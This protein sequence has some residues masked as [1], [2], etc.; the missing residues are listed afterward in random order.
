MGISK[1]YADSGRFVN[2]DV[3]DGIQSN[4]F[5]LGAYFKGKDGKFY[6]GGMNGYNVFDPEDIKYNTDKPVT[7]VA[8][9]RK[10]N[11]ILPVEYRNGDT[12]R[13][14]HDENFFSI[15]ISA[16]DYTNPAKNRYRYKLDDVDNDWIL[17]DANDRVAEYKNV[18]PGIYSFKAIGSNND[19]IW[20]DTPVSLTIIIK[21]PWWTTWWFRILSTLILIA[22]IVFLN[23]RR[24]QR[25][26][27]KH[28]VEKKLLEIEKQKFDLEQKALRLQ[29]NPHF[30][31]NS[32]NSIQSYILSNDAE[33]AVLYLGKFS[34]LMRLILT[35]SSNQYI[36]LKEELNAITHYL[37]LEKLRF[38]NKFDYTIK[39]DR[40]LDEEFVDIPPM[41]IQPYIEN[42][43]I[44]GLLHKGTKGKID[45]EFKG[46]DKKIICTITDDGV[47][48]QRSMEIDKQ[49]GIKRK[50]RGML[51][52]Q[53]RLEILN[54]QSEDEF[55]VRIF[56]L[57][58]ESGN[59]S[60]TKV[61]LV[62][63]YKEE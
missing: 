16:L 28:E 41:I 54:R 63:Q 39:I 52:T 47:G 23:Y 60:G 35:H 37:D 34:Q 4:E 2:Y 44:H 27:K 29:M 30:I 42:A 43:I 6:F 32:L 57:K 24:F 61:E 11:D 33:K 17:T 19:G 5:N 51:I 10:F 55:S 18:Q 26:K 62:I 14:A 46:E 56:D 58:D 22:L 20:G 31:F 15:E 9:F 53:A 50:S 13:L 12:I 1:L 7:V 45:I 40:S 49:S 38:E 36:S 25:I 21:P 48:R 8:A 3:K 59:P